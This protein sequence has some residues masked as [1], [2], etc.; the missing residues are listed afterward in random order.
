MTSLA[1]GSGFELVWKYWIRSAL[2][3]CGFATLIWRILDFQKSPGAIGWPLITEVAAKLGKFVLLSITLIYQG[4]IWKLKLTLPT[5]VQYNTTIIT[6]TA[7]VVINLFPVL[8]ST[9]YRLSIFKKELVFPVHW[10]G[11]VSSPA[12]RSASSVGWTAAGGSLHIQ[13]QLFLALFRI[14][15]LRVHMFLDLPAPDP[16]P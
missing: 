8:Q 12:E 3:Q 7:C 14:R 13:I 16:D 11:S 10:W 2:K 5:S 4:C 1:S 15:I 9:N 6:A